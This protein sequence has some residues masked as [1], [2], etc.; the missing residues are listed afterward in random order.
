M[1]PKW[2]TATPAK[3]DALAQVGKDYLE[4]RFAGQSRDVG[5]IFAYRR[6]RA[7]IQRQEMAALFGWDPERPVVGIYGSNWIDV[8]APPAY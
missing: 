6:N 5:G 2:G 4:Q 1:A 7:P 3:A 8:P